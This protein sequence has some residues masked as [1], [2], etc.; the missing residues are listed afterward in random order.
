MRKL[1]AALIILVL[2][3]PN[4]SYAEIETKTKFIQKNS[5]NLSL[6]D[7]DKLNARG[8]ADHGRYHVMGN[9]RRPGR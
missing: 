3:V 5:H 2:F 4:I 6:W 9:F 8:K 7:D 1:L